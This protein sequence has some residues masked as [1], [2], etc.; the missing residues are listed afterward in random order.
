MGV[1][2]HKCMSTLDNYVPVPDVDERID[3]ARGIMSVKQKKPKI[4]V[5]TVTTSQ[6]TVK[7]TVSKTS[8]E[9][10]PN[11]RIDVPKAGQAD[12]SKTGS[13]KASGSKTGGP[14]ASGSKTGDPK[15]SGSKTDDPRASGSKTDGPKA[16]G[17]KTCGPKAGGPKAGGRTSH[18]HEIAEQG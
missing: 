14:K 2:E 13:P 4:L 10:N 5:E 9:L 8:I 6:T 17:S 15:A 3:G 7:K 18:Q 11:C 12:S 16:S 1:T